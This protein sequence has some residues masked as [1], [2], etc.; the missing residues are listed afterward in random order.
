MSQ[1]NTLESGANEAPSC[2]GMSPC[3]SLAHCV[4]LLGLVC[5]G[6]VGVERTD[7]MVSGD[8]NCVVASLGAAAPVATCVCV[9]K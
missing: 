1:V 6:K 5:Q 7:V 8:C 9:L 3:W 4:V 2:D